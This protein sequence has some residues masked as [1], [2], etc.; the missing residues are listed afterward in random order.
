MEDRCEI[1]SPTP[2][3]DL[4]L[5]NRAMDEGDFAHAAH[6]LAG[7]LGV[8]PEQ[9]GFEAAFA[10]FVGGASAPLALVELGDGASYR[11]LVALRALVLH[12]LGQDGEAASLL[13]QV[14]A[15][16]PELPFAERIAAWLGSERFEPS[17]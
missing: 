9:R 4:D 17:R 1:V 5:A 12:H 15:S 16:G 13:I 8:H 11:G 2:E 14:Q 10:R 3:Q 7:V 6:H